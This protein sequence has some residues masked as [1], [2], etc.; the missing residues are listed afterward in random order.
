[1]PFSWPAKRSVDCQLPSIKDLQ[2]VR[3]IEKRQTTLQWDKSSSDPVT[4]NLK[5][6]LHKVGGP[7]FPSHR[8]Y[9]TMDVASVMSH[10]LFWRL[11]FGILAVAILDFLS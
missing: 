8:L 6:Q 11:K 5:G 3:S 9:K 2:D 7:M 10:I 4:C 1:M